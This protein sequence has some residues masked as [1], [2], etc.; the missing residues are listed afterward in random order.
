[1]I[2]IYMKINMIYI[3][4]IYFDIYMYM[5]KSGID[6]CVLFLFPKVQYSVSLMNSN[7]RLNAFQAASNFSFLLVNSPQGI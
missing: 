3:Y 1:M 4:I 7:I 5:Q 6:Y 2:Y